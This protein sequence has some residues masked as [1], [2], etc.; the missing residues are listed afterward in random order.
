[1]RRDRLIFVYNADSGILN[2]GMHG[3]HKMLFPSSYPCSLCA[4]TYGTFSMRKE[5]KAFIEELSISV[6]FMH[7]DEWLKYTD[8]SDDL[9][10]VLYENSRGIEVVLSKSQLDVMV[11]NEL[12]ESISQWIKAIE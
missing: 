2:T 5:W 4:I 1:M 12:M 8:R 7:R 10:A 6:D 9:P 3:M 11:L